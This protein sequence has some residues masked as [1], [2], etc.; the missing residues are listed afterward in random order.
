LLSF[1][2]DIELLPN[3]KLQIWDLLWFFWST[4]SN[5]A[6][7]RQLHQIG[8]LPELLNDDGKSLVI[9]RFYQVVV[10]PQRVAMFDLGRVIGSREHDDRHFFELGVA[11]DLAQD[12]DPVDLGHA[13]LLWRV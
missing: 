9:D 11:F 8:K 4:S 7:F 6:D 12:L 3:D 2:H 5:Q 10:A 1:G 13:D